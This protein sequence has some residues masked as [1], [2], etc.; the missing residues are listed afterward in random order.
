[1]WCVRGVMCVVLCVCGVRG[2]HI[3]PSIIPPP[4][5]ALSTPAFPSEPCHLPLPLRRA[6]STSVSL[7][8][9]TATRSIFPPSPLPWQLSFLFA[10]LNI[11][12]INPTLN[13]TKLC[14]A[15]TGSGLVRRLSSWESMELS[16]GGGSRGGV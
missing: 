15:R 5:P 8:S 11:L 13:C 9:V 14:L 16:G 2:A 7:T 10:V 3:S 4:L 6:S 1:M 12:C